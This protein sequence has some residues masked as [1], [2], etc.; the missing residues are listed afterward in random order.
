MDRGFISVVGLLI[1]VV[2][3]RLLDLSSYGLIGIISIFI[4]TAQTLIDSG[5]SN[6]LI[7]RK[8]RT[9]VDF[10]TIFYSNVVVALLDIAF[11]FRI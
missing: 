10:S 3:V 8:N 1:G 4:T 7:Q 11:V 5:V 9:E 2:I 6:S